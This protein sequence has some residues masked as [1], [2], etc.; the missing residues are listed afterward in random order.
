MRMHHI[1]P[2]LAKPPAYQ[3]GQGWI[4]DRQLGER[5]SGSQCAQ[6]DPIEDALDRKAY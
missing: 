2:A 6:L 1:E 4:V 5:G 3:T